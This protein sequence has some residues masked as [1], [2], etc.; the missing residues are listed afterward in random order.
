MA[1][2]FV[3]TD[4][5][6][7]FRNRA[8]RQIAIRNHEIRHP[9]SEFGQNRRPRGAVADL[10]KAEIVQH[11]PE[12]APMV[13]LPID[14]QHVDFFVGNFFAIFTFRNRPGLGFRNSIFPRFPITRFHRLLPE[15][16]SE[17][18]VASGAR[19]YRC[20]LLTKPLFYAGF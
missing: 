19:I 18:R 2:V 4:V 17:T 8:V 1:P 3:V 11:V 9:F 5:R 16:M 20:P 12:A 15:T 14:N 10:A 13:C 7:Q 6:N